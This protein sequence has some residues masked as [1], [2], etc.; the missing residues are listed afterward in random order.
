MVA[1][2][3]QAGRFIIKPRAMGRLDCAIE[4]VA[5]FLVTVFRPMEACFIH[6]VI[7]SFRERFQPHHVYTRRD[8]GSIENSGAGFYFFL[9]LSPITPLLPPVYD[10]H[11][12]LSPTPH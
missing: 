2:A 9:A 10:G 5:C 7:G 4:M 6:G 12:P 3:L 1:A 11:K 8:T